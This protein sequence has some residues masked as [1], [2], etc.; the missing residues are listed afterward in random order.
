MDE[1]RWISSDYR[2][3]GIVN[4]SMWDRNLDGKIICDCKAFAFRGRTI[5]ERRENAIILPL[6]TNAYLDDLFVLQWL[7]KY[8]MIS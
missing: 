1:L 8:C 6:D 3:L 4:W 5:R 2:Q 7:R